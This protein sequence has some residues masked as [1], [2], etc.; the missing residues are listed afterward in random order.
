MNLIGN[1]KGE[2]LVGIIVIIIFLCMWIFTPA[3]LAISGIWPGGW[4]WSGFWVGLALLLGSFELYGKFFSKEK[5]TL[6]N[7]IRRWA[8]QSKKNLLISR[9]VLLIWTTAWLIL[10]F[11]HLWVW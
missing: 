8:K 5:L 6:T 11:C 1:Q 2:S 9:A 7:H 10:I 4:I 3:L